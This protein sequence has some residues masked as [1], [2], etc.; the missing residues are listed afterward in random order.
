[1]IIRSFDIAKEKDVIYE[2]NVTKDII[3]D[4]GVSINTDN[5]K[6]TFLMGERVAID[7]EKWISVTDGKSVGTNDF[8]FRTSNVYNYVKDSKKSVYENTNFGGIYY[9]SYVLED[10][11]MIR[12][13][14][15]D[16]DKD[17]VI[18]Q[19]WVLGDNRL[20]DI[21]TSFFDNDR[22]IVDF[23]DSETAFINCF[24][25]ILEFVRWSNGK[26]CVERYNGKEVYI[27]RA[28][29]TIII[30]GNAYVNGS[31]SDNMNRI[32]YILKMKLGYADV[33]MCVDT[34]AIEIGKNSGYVVFKD[35][36]LENTV[37]T[38]ITQ[39]QGKVSFEMYDFD[40]DK[41]VKLDLNNRLKSENK[42]LRLRA[43]MHAGDT[44]KRIVF[45]K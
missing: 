22:E 30:N 31:I 18:Y 23:T 44:I 21:F 13:T 9:N 1:M 26:N 40:L 12:M 17:R 32:I 10:D 8:K 14:S 27:N 2:I 15:L 16:S 36:E 43:Y 45:T 6:L 35:I 39:T 28:Q 42:V 37:S 5:N 41:W 33:D 7:S 29:G 38:M 11:E 24:N 25:E 4:N 34:S 19:Q 3:T 20:V